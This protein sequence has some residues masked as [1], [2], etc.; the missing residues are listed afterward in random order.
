MLAPIVLFVYARPEHT[1]KT[2]EAL[3]KNELSKESKLFIFSDAPKGKK[4]IEK[5]E[6]VRNYIL[7]LSEKNWFESVSVHMSTENKGL[8][9]SVIEGVTSKIEEFGKVIVLE[10][11]LVTSPDFLSYMNQALN[12]YEKNDDIW[13]ICGYTFNINFPNGY[14]DDV[15]LA[16]RGGSW[17]WATWIDRWIQVDWEV[18]DY[19][20]FKKDKVVRKKLNCGGRDMADMLDAQMN[21]KIDSWAIR[22]CYTQSKLNK[23]TIYP[24][25]S[26]VKNIGLDGTGTHSGKNNKFDV[27]IPSSGEKVNLSNPKL[28]NE[29]LKKFK[30]YFGTKWDWRIIRLKRTIKKIMKV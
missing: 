13:S 6:K 28:N 7:S 23:F 19:P 3:A 12:Y 20:K 15:Y 27:T 10:D 17:G 16:Y 5:V 2:V 29:I 4:D 22:W 8:A 21:G 18:K 24:I 26:R 11:D 14:S 1:I 30:D 9:N 25:K